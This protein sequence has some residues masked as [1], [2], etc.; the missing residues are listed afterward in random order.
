MM[1]AHDSTSGPQRLSAETLDTLRAALTAYITSPG[2]DN[3]LRAALH[4]VADEARSK[5]IL[6]ERRLISL[7]EMW[8]SLPSVGATMDNDAQVRL[9]QR[10]VTM[11]IKEYYR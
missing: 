11:C 7:K 6:P 3:S 9:L 10:V 1:M 5:S 2:D 4:S 8:Y